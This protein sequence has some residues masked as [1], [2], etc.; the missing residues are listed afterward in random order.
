M[1]ARL[2]DH[3]VIYLCTILENTEMSTPEY[4]QKY[5]IEIR[6]CQVA[7][8]RRVFDKNI[9]VEV[10]K[11]VVGTSAMPIAE[12]RRSYRTG[13]FI[14]VLYNFRVAFF[15]MNY[16]HY[17]LGITRTDW[18]E[19]VLNEVIQA[20][21]SDYPVMKRAL[22][23]I[24]KQMDM[25]LGG[26]SSV[27]KVEGLGEMVLSPYEAL[28]YLLLE[29]KDDLYEE[30]QR[31]TQRFCRRHNYEISANNLNDIFL[32]QKIR[33]PVWPLPQERSHEF[34]TNIPYYFQAMLLGQALPALIEQTVN[35][36]L[37]VS[38]QKFNSKLDAFFARLR[39]G[40]TFNIY[41]VNIQGSYEIQA[42]YQKHY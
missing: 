21:K 30:L 5:Q 11:I 1:T 23:H 29:N 4:I 18:V 31:I 34:K 37:T 10:E 6:T 13:Y 22:D 39:S 26:I 3:F 41:D 14:A 2:D 38:D 25:I 7:M 19:F 42:S 24:E 32:Y 9:P 28:L 16:F 36:E 35:V 40:H 17:Q 33:M 27:S 20:A 12:W 15:V 8:T